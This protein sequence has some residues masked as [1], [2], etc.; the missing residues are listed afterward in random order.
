[1]FT[2]LSQFY[3]STEWCNLRQ[4]LLNERRNAEDG[5]LYDEYDGSVIVDECDAIIHHKIYL[6]EQNVN[7]YNISLNPDNLMIVSHANHNRIHKRFEW[8]KNQWQRKVY[9]VFGCACSGKSSYVRK[10]MTAG[11]LVLDVDELWR[12]VSLQDAHVYSDDLKPIVFGMRQ[13][14]LDKIKVRDG[15]WDVAWVLSTEVLPIEQQRLCERLGGEPIFI[16]TGK[17]E[18]LRRLRDNPN[19]RDVAVFEGVIADY[20]SKKA[21]YSEN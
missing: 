16:D 12:A 20:F 2:S 11:D 17:D 18:C 1:M 8:K 9:I 5:L 10:N 21:I 7:D 19:G 3:C 4:Q 6:T 14:L 15:T 13:F